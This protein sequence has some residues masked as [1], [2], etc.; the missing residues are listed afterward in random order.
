MTHLMGA[1]RLSGQAGRAARCVASRKRPNAAGE[2]ICPTEGRLVR[3]AGVVT[4][5]W[6]CASTTART[7]PSLR[8]AQAGEMSHYQRSLV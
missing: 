1:D 2:P 7:V 4:A 6:W 5:R 8:A 3:P